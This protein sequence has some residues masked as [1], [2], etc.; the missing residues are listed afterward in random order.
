MDSDL[1]ISVPEVLRQQAVDLAIA[2]GA[3]VENVVRE[4]IAQY[5]SALA[6]EKLSAPMDS[7]PQTELG[8]RLRILRGQILAAEASPLGW[9]DL[10]R[11]LA[12]RRGECDHA[13]FDLR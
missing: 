3:T 13:A 11:E 9:E 12:E 4:A 5:V 2:R 7:L 6:P 1:T 8:A 10:Q